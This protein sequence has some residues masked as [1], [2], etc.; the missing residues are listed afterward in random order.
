MTPKR[1]SNHYVTIDPKAY[2]EIKK[3]LDVALQQY[4]S[5]DDNKVDKLVKAT[6]E[7]FGID[8]DTVSNE[9]ITRL[10]YHSSDDFMRNNVFNL[11]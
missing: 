2:S 7:E 1:Q 11:A 5:G 3:R 10:K 9:D 6:L 8:G 4:K